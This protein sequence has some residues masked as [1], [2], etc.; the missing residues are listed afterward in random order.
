M[1]EFTQRWSRRAISIS[2]VLVAWAVTTLTLPLAVPVIGL[3]DALARRPKNWPTLRAFS[4]LFVLLTFEVLGVG[5]A[6]AIWI[7]GLFVS[8]DRF[9][10]WN[11]AVQT[12]WTSTLFQCAK[13]IFHLSLTL[14]GLENAARAPYLL[15]VR[16]SSIADT[17]LPATLIG[18]QYGI[19]LR[20]VL[21][22]ELLWD[23]CLD[24]VGNRL[25]NAFVDRSGAV[26][27]R[28]LA[29]VRGL[30]TELSPNEAVLIYP[31]GTR[32]TADKLKRVIAK[33]QVSTSSELAAVASQ[34]N[35]ILPPRKG[36]PLA[37]L[38]VVPPLDVVFFAH[39]GLEGAVGLSNLMAGDLFGAEL[40]VRVWRVP[41]GDLPDGEE[42]RLRWLFEQWLKMDVWVGAQKTNASDT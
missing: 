38:S 22:K 35:H 37:L 27:D 40:R 26:R 12:W 10:A 13:R 33:S 16:H 25:P 2:S 24:I 42:E 7:P 15:F 17:V 19:R 9:V 3:F 31:E 41:S 23:P 18:R 4:F 6:F 36:G 30:A 5:M 21:K 11:S 34:F 14:E 20:Y 32:F 39:V 28:E 29:Q 8:K 1:I